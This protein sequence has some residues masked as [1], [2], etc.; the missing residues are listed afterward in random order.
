MLGEKG[1][2]IVSTATVSTRTRRP[3]MR[4]RFSNKLWRSIK[5]EPRSGGKLQGR[6]KRE[7]DSSII[8]RKSQAGAAAA[9]NWGPTTQFDPQFF[10]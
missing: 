10:P 4:A 7:R 3:Q 5:Q 1:G 9:V 8:V 6:P 2:E